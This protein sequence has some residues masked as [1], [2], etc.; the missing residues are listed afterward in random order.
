M[1]KP[2]PVIKVLRRN[3][4]DTSIWDNFIQSTPQRTIYA[5]SWWLDIIPQPWGAVVE[6]NSKGDWVAVLPYQTKQKYGLTKVEQDA[7]TNELGVY[8]LPSANPEK[9]IAFFFK[10]FK[11]ISRYYFNC[12]NQFQALDHLPFETTFHLSLHSDYHSL[13]KGY[14]NN[15]IR[16]ANKNQQVIKST[17]IDPLLTMFKKYVAPNINGIVDD[18]YTLLKS[19]YHKASRDDLG[20]ILYV[21]NESDEI[22]SGTLF[23]QSFNRLI[24]F[25]SASTPAGWANNSQALL[26]DHI[27]QQHAN[28]PLILDFEGGS[29]DGIGKFY[30]SFGAE[31]VKIYVYRKML[32]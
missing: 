26:I 27:I 15:R 3:Q 28:S 29:V 5:M 17:D 31:E 25:F 30:S 20:F 1:K 7:F 19:L 8:C 22:L 21:K 13:K 16:T 6:V 2:K 32:F 9:I 18:Q 11:F 4:I 14:S 10:K 23:L 24:Y 12:N